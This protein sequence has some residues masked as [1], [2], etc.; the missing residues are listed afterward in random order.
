MNKIETENI[1]KTNIR[2]DKTKIDFQYKKQ[3]FN[4]FLTWKE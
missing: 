2:F 3:N 4:G 1:T